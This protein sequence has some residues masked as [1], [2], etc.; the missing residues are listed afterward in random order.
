MPVAAVVLERFRPVNDVFREAGR[1]KDRVRGRSSEL[2]WTDGK[3]A[4]PAHG[5]IALLR[6]TFSRCHLGLS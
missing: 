1:V 5:S 4:R 6:G 3:L 2:E